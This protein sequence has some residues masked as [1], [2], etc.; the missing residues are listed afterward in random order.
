MEILRYTKAHVNEN[1]GTIILNGSAANNYNSKVLN[2]IA[3][4]ASN[5]NAG[6][7]KAGDISANNIDATYI[8]T[9]DLETNNITTNTINSKYGVISDLRSDDI[10]TDNLNVKNQATVNQLITNT[11]DS[12]SIVTDY[13]TVNKSAHFFELII[14][15]IRSVEGTQIHTAAN[16]VADFTQAMNA[17]NQPIAINS[18]NADHYRV[19]FK[20]EDDN[21]KISNNWII[22]DQ[23]I[24]QSFNVTEG[25][26]YDTK[27]KYY[28]RLVTNTSSTTGQTSRFVNLNEEYINDDK[29]SLTAK[30]FNIYFDDGFN[31]SDGNNDFNDFIIEAINPGEYDL[32]TDIW[33]PSSTQY[34]LKIYNKDYFFIDGSFFF[35]THDLTTLNIAVVYEDGSVDYWEAENYNDSYSVNTDTDKY[36]DYF[37][38]TTNIVEKWDDCHWID[39]SNTIKDTNSWAAQDA[40]QGILSDIP[41]AGDNICQLGYRFGAGASQ[42]DIARSSAIIIAAYKSPDDYIVPPSYA[43][44]QYITDFDLGSHRKTFFDAKEA[45]IIGNFVVDSSGVQTDLDDYIRQQTQPQPVDLIVRDANAK[46]T[47][48][49]MQ[50][51]SNGLITDLNNFP[52]TTDTLGGRDLYIETYPPI[53]PT[54]IFP[55]QLK[56]DL[57]G[58]TVTIMTLDPNTGNPVI[59]PNPDTGDGIY[60]NSATFGSSTLNVNFRFRGNGQQIA[61]GSSINFYGQIIVDRGTQDERTIN[62]SQAITIATVSDS[63]GND[64]EIYT[65]IK[66]MEQAT[67]DNNNT[68]NV[69]FKYKVSHVIGASAAED[70]GNC[71]LRIIAYDIDNNTIG[72]PVELEPSDY[73]AN[74]WTWTNTINNWWEGGEHG[75]DG[76][77]LYYKVQLGQL[78]NSQFVIYQTSII[79][80]EPLGTSLFINTNDLFERITANSESI[81]DLTLRSDE[82]DVSITNL[83][84]DIDNTQG[85]LDNYKQAVQR[86]G[87]NV[88]TGKITLTA[89]NTEITGDLTLR[90]SFDSNNTTTMNRA[91]IDSTNGGI[92]LWGPNHVGLD[93]LPTTGAQQVEIIK[94]GYDTNMEPRDPQGFFREGYIEILDSHDPHLGDTLIKPDK[95]TIDWPIYNEKIEFDPINITRTSSDNINSNQQTWDDILCNRMRIKEIRG[96]Y[97]ADTPSSYTMKNEDVKYDVF[98]VRKKSGDTTAGTFTIYLPDP[99][100]PNKQL[101]WLGKKIYLKHIGDGANL[102]IQITGGASRLI[103]GNNNSATDSFDCDAYSLMLICVDGYWIRWRGDD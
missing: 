16:C 18:Q 42:D 25:T 95:L 60:I 89:Q 53:D 34:G 78:I 55:T 80:V 40:S 24:C 13:L 47:M 102:Q 69:N 27:N 52:G 32:A 31:F 81:A 92:T 41:T 49:V 66:E 2:V 9:D 97:N 61:N 21:R 44:Y 75:M 83:N 56:C 19:Y 37:L 86:T 7:I 77:P 43:Q 5:V 45:K 96:G 8:Y 87:I 11:L 58:R 38:I 46:V 39:L 17:S 94:M 101:Y 30:T 59:M 88:Q 85:D 68:L 93:L 71:S 4:N 72:I 10:E 91:Y 76:K 79:N 26:T 50:L 29:V 51:D 15:K 82:F 73:T 70:V 28:W 84:T 98:I 23:A 3:L 54:R 74:G 90:G 57:F 63:Q 6:T 65:L 33:T 22:N 12:K 64:G 35:S 14:D 20:K 48:C 1:G 103:D 62:A 99:S 36:V 100:D 67:V